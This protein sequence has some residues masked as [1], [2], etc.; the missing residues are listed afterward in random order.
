MQINVIKSFFIL[1]AVMS[2]GHSNAITVKAGSYYLVDAKTDR[3]L[4]EKNSEEKMP[5]ASITKT[6]TAYV[7]FDKISKGDVKLDEEVEISR[8]ASRKGG[9]KMF[10]KA[11]SLVKVSDLLRGMI[12]SSGN[13]AAIALAELVGGTEE[14][15]AVIM[16]ETAVKL[17]M[18]NSNFENATG[19]PAKNHY[20]TA[21]DI[22]ILSKALINDFPEL[23]KIFGEKSF[24][25]GKSPRGRAIKQINR[26][27]LLW[28]RSIK[29]DGIKT[30]HTK[31]AG[32]CLVGS[33]VKDGM[34]LISVVMKTNSK[35][36]R[37]SQ[38]K[39]LLNY[40][41]RNYRNKKVLNVNEILGKIKVWKGSISELNVGSNQE[42]LVTVQK[43]DLQKIKHKIDID[44]SVV[45]PVK[46]HQKL[47][48]VTYTTPEGVVAT[49]DIVAL[50]SVPEGGLVGNLVDT[51]MMKLF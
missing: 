40:G 48:T 45:A 6:M 12:V 43:I 44:K 38:S 23:Y 26:N 1:L 8:K 7:L 49:V 17:G 51:L 24:T 28:S 41:L 35:R 42:V 47:G 4:A 39:A 22:A 15:F 25:Y 2:Y 34:R 36:S 37:V 31:E 14:S 46:L 5:P 50:E 27:G 11:F 13:D 30:G 10:I 29:A 32:Y 19:W 3:V 9:S 33:A 20:T 18:V 16:N 21:K